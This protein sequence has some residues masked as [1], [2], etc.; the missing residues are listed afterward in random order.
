MMTASQWNQEESFLITEEIEAD[1]LP[2]AS[3]AVIFRKQ[4]KRALQFTFIA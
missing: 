4:Q 2:V 3:H 1:M